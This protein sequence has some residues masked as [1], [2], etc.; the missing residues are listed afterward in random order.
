MSWLK[1]SDAA[2]M[3]PDV[4]RVLE[5][6]E[7]DDRLLNEMYGWL[8]RCATQCAAYD[9]DYIIEV[10][11]A[12]TM[13]GMS[14]YP[15]LLAA[16][17][18][19][20]LLEH[21][22]IDGK[23]GQRRKV[24][25]LVEDQ[26]LFHMILKSDKERE[27]NRRTD[28]YDVAKK[29]A[30]I[31]RDG[32]N[33]RWCDRVVTWNNDRKSVKAGTIDHLDPKDLDDSEP[34]PIERLAVACTSCNSSRKAGEYWDKE[35]LPVPQRPYYSEDA[36]RWL[37]EK[38]GV[39]VQVT[40]PRIQTHTPTPT[41]APE[42]AQLP[43]PAGATAADDATAPS[44][45]SNSE[46]QDATAQSVVET[47]EATAPPAQG[48]IE[49][50]SHSDM[51]AAVDDYEA[52]I[53]E[54]AQQAVEIP[55][56]GET[57]ANGGATATSGAPRERQQSINAKSTNDQLIIKKSE[58]DGSGCAGT[59]RDGPGWVGKRDSSSTHASKPERIPDA[60][61]RRSRRSRPRRR[62]K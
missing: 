30:I 24:L 21:K 35:L 25:K 1:Q 27:K 28:T 48:R 5:M 62:K 37:K 19:C 23:D 57:P 29:A 20:G 14:R 61:R 43:A 60:P 51:A 58:G 44:G 26:D 56:Q 7:C 36:Q 45:A 55:H 16:A 49:R 38:A 2:A 39:H 18:Y 17:V 15:A 52:M 12:K 32:S 4:L 10:G 3:H 6:E 13:A 47:P 8:N 40:Q 11:T 46:P 33:C 34:T 54:L 50:L 41:P 9:R 59:G 53:N 31:K 42:P 22:E